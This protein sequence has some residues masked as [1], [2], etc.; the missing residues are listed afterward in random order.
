MSGAELHASGGEEAPWQRLSSR[1]IWVDL[2]QS[3]LSLAPGAIAIGLL[4]VDPSPGTVWPLAVIALL[5][6]VGAVNDAARWVFTR[7]RVTDTEVQRRSGVIIRR[8]RSVRRERIRS[9]DTHAKLRHRLAG[10]RVVAIGAGQQVTANEAAFDL[11]ALAKTDAFALRRR[12]M[13]ERAGPGTDRTKGED[14]IEGAGSTEVF[15]RFRA[16]WV[17]YNVFSIWAYL[18]ATAVLWGAFWIAATFG[19]D[20][21]GVVSGLADWRELGWVRTIAVGALATGIIGAVGMATSYFTGYWRFE[22]ARVRHENGSH[23]RTR[24]GL[25]STREVSRDETRT[26]GLSISEPLLWRWMG[27]ADTNIITTGLGLW[28]LEQPTALLPRGPISVARLVAAHVLGE[29]CPITAELA[30]HPRTAL[31]RRLW[32]ATLVIGT[33]VAFLTAPVVTEA[34]PLWVL[35]VALGC[36][37]LALLGAL[38]A[39]RSLGHTL[40]GEYVVMR[41]GLMTRTTSAL[42]RDAVSTIAVRQSV[43]QQR[44]GLATVSTMTAAGWSVYEAPDVGVDEAF[45]FADEAAPG[46]LTPF[47]HRPD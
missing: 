5:G 40:H 11:N 14:A 7:Y 6:I 17:A 42:R 30:R 16:W 39:Y 47:L 4:G 36:W 9:V 28:S 29:P 24:R 25:F 21:V 33:A 12:L 27:M 34:A 18:M 45:A 23:L 3:L 1:M 41:S 8:Y 46:L 19:V 38:I 2:V 20:L 44:L 43:L 37:P 35:W 22:L 31:R 15:A 10:L 32:W 13:Q 26:R